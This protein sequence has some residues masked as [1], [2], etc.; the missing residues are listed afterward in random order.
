MEMVISNHFPCKDLVH[1]PIETTIKNWLFGVHPQK[2]TAWHLKIS[3]LKKENHLNQTSMFGATCLVFG[4]V[5]MKAGSLGLLM[6][7]YV[8]KKYKSLYLCKLKLALLMFMQVEIGLFKC[9]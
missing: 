5:D 4:G 9:V 7:I 1:H 8:Y 6:Y 3:C 2:L